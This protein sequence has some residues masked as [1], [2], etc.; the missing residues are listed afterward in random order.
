MPAR[1]WACA[2]IMA[3][4]MNSPHT[5]MRAKLKLVRDIGRPSVLCLEFKL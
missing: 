2:V 5:I 4:K 3:E 1:N